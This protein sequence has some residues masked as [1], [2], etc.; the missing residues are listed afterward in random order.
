M[1]HCSR[2]LLRQKIHDDFNET[3]YFL[4]FNPFYVPRQLA[5][6]TWQLWMW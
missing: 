6:E 3:R 2:D 1:L 5:P 4:Y